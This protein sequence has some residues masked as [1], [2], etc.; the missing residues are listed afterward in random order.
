MEREYM[1]S[2]T[3]RRVFRDYHRTEVGMYNYDGCFDAA[4]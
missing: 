1:R 4:S 2:R 3:I